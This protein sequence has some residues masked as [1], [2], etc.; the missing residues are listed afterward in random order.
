MFKYKLS[1][2]IKRLRVR[3]R[4][5]RRRFDNKIGP[6]RQITSSYQ[7]KGIRLWKLVLKDKDSRLAVNTN[8][9]RQIEKDN[10]LM[11]FQ[12][13]DGNSDSILTIMDITDNGNNIYELHI[14]PKEAYNICDYFDDE[15]DRRMNKV[16]K[17]KR[18]IIE[19]DLDKL[20]NLQE[21]QL[22]K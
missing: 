5:W 8:G 13:T 7:E 18:L 12:Y 14:Y 16:E 3:V 17:T 1:Y 19:T 21:T 22:K 2:R 15:M 11:V 4:S 9:V 10:L 6:A 20:L